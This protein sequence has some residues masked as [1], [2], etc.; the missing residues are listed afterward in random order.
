MKPRSIITAS[1]A[2]VALS[3]S[4]ANAAPVGDGITDVSADFAE[5]RDAFNASEAEVR[6]LLLV[7]PT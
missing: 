5:L 2:L 1:L 7:S 6:L 4:V 3:L